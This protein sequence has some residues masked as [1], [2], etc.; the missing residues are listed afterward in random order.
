MLGLEHTITG[1][2]PGFQVRGAHIKKMRRAE[3]GGKIFVV[4]RV[5]NHDFTPKN[6]IFSN[7][8]SALGLE[9]TLTDV[10]NQLTEFPG[11][12]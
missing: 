9:H 6:H 5:K 12:I 2:E 10:L 8:R 7:F 11:T 3:G 4:F 1:A